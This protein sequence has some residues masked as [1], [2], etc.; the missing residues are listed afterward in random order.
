VRGE[1]QDMYFEVSKNGDLTKKKDEPSSP[2]S[3]LHNPVFVV[4]DPSIKP[5]K[6]KRKRRPSDLF[7]PKKNKPPEPVLKPAPPASA[8]AIDHRQKCAHC[9]ML[10]FLVGCI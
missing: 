8:V 1:F 4:E 9:G 5:R 2:E 10:L 3:L 7:R 6:P